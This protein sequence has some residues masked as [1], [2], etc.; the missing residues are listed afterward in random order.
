[1]S[2][3]IRGDFGACR[4]SVAGDRYVYIYRVPFQDRIAYQS[5]YYVCLDMAFNDK[6]LQTRQYGYQ[7]RVERDIKKVAF[8]AFRINERPGVGKND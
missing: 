6:T 5:A 3:E 8:H 4:E 1:M 2:S 7:V